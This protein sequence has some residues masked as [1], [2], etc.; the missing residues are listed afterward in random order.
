VTPEGLRGAIVWAVTPY[1]PE[2][3][4]RLLEPSHTRPRTFVTARDVSRALA[5]RNL[6]VEQTYLV[7]GKVRPVVLLHDRPR[8]ALREYAVLQLVRLE[9]FPEVDRERIR[10]H[11]TPSLL[12]LAAGRYRSRKEAAIDLNSLSRVHES[13]IVGAPVGRLDDHEL[14]LVGERLAEYLDL[15][16]SRLVEERARELLEEAIALAQADEPPAR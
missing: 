16:L 11:G 10:R 13:A 14:R 3:P 2:A 5:A 7:P 6:D 15:D 4:V 12:H 1:V 8:R 9:T